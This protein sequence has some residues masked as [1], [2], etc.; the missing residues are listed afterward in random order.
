MADAPIFK[1][2]LLANLAGFVLALAAVCAAIDSLLP[3]L[4]VL[5][6]SDKLDE[7]R[8]RRGE[9]DTVFVG[10][11]RVYHAF[12]PAQ[13]DRET[14]ARGMPARSFNFGIDGMRP[15]ESLYVLREVLRLRLPLRSVFIELVDVHPKVNAAN[16]GTARYV[17]WHDARHTELVLRHIFSSSENA[18]DK[19]QQAL[20][21]AG[22]FLARLSNIGRGQEWLGAKLREPQRAP[23]IAMPWEG[24]RGFEA[25][26]SPQLAGTRRANFESAVA[27][28]EKNALAQT[29]VPPLLAA[30]LR[31]V[32]AE[33]RAAGARPVFVISPTVLRNENFADLAAAGIDAP[34]IAFNDPRR[35]AAVFRAENHCDEQHLNA[36]GAAE[37]TRA[38]AEAPGSARVPRAGAGVPASAD[39][40]RRCVCA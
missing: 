29:P 28:L 39:F 27:F 5:G 17:H 35:H 23:R 24:H 4:R 34:V 10:S 7:L 25:Q 26:T 19:W 36:T 15:P 12:D 8:A 38:L 14:A 1:R 3:S 16:I 33:V 2:R 11:S 40:T 37:F 22:C 13:F 18:A 31:D 20:V 32:V 21:H 6:I 30:A 9:I